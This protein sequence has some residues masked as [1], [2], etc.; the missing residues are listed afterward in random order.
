MLLF[1]EFLFVLQVFKIIT[2]SLFFLIYFNPLYYYF[3]S[4]KHPFIL[5]VTDN[6]NIQC[7][8]GSDS[9]VPWIAPMVS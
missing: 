5:C 1:L 6:Y 2:F 4:I 7:H 9:F 3:S 8:L